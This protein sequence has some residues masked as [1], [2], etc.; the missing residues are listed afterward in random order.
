MKNIN[1][2]AVTSSCHQRSDLSKSKGWAAVASYHAYF[3]LGNGSWR[4]Q[5]GRII[6]LVAFALTSAACGRQTDR[7][8]AHVKFSQLA[9]VG[10][11]S[12]GERFQLQ[13]PMKSYAVEEMAGCSNRGEG[14]GRP[15]RN[16]RPRGGNW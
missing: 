16:Y 13:W 7:S 12:G 1:A 11:R 8:T 15:G 10:S 3:R 4:R 2:A 5:A 6:R 14:A 9:T